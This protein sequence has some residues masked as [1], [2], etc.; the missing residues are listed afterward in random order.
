MH[1]SIWAQEWKI[2]DHILL[3]D[4]FR[5]VWENKPKKFP[6]MYHLKGG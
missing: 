1:S 4:Q 6:F 3:D 5:K 2:G